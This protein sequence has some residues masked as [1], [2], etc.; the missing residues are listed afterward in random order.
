MCQYCFFIPG[1]VVYTIAIIL[2]PGIPDKD[3][4]LPPSLRS[5]DSEPLLLKPVH[6]FIG[7]I[8]RITQS[9]VR[10]ISIDAL[11][12]N[13]VVKLAE[14]QEMIVKLA[15]DND[16]YIAIASQRSETIPAAEQNDGSNSKGKELPSL[17]ALA[18]ATYD[19]LNE[20]FSFLRILNFFLALSPLTQCF[21]RTGRYCWYCVLWKYWQFLLL[22]VGV[23]T[24]ISYKCL[25]L[26]ERVL[27]VA[28]RNMIDQDFIEAVGC[29][30][31]SKAILWQI[32]PPLSVLSIWCKNTSNSP[33][34]V[35]SVPD[36]FDLAP[37]YFD[38]SFMTFDFSNT[39]DEVCKNILILFYGHV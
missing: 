15:I 18:S 39:T 13:Q 20:A 11:V 9:V 5:L 32:I 36:F 17:L 1:P 8:D 6:T 4:N 33:L 25:N 7:F 38:L 19:E 31:S 16:T 27:A 12:L 35:L 24:D 22:T 21:T 3:S 26:P 30:I 37:S 34:Y 10:L 29:L 2:H 14:I 23:W 28:N